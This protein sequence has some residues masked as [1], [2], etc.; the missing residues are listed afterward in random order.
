MPKVKI[1]KANKKPPK[2]TATNKKSLWTR[3]DDEE[4]LEKLK[5]FMQL[6]PTCTDVSSFF[7]VADA[8]VRNWIKKEFGSTYDS[9]RSFHLTDVK[10]RLTGKAI[11][12][13][14]K[15]E[16][17]ML[18]FALQ[19]LCDWTE[20]SKVDASEIAALLGEVANYSDHEVDEKIK[21]LAE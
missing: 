5:A 21:E 13:A 16:R 19:N 4:K 14:E 1:T 3:L 18:K 20:K 15:G 2:I 7:G 9:F 17:T 11:A 10:L 6:N 12:M 8:T